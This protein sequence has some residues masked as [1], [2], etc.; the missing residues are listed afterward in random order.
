MRD[1]IA[2]EPKG[3]PVPIRRKQDGRF[4]PGASGNPNGR[5]KG[6][7]KATNILLESILE[8][9]G[10]ALLRRA[11]EIALGDRGG[12]TLRALLP[13]LVAPLPPRGEHI[14]IDLP[15][16]SSATEAARAAEA[17]LAAVGAGAIT[18]E[19]GQQLIAMLGNVAKARETADLE[20]RIAAIE[21]TSK[22]ANSP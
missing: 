1:S 7:R 4:A 15:P 16:L 13:L 9:N 6:S 20:A 14:E 2:P 22:K 21:A 8:E 19:T 5:P 3:Q 10:E 17:V 11:V 12:P 18:V